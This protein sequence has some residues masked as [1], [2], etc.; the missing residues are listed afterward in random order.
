MQ[1]DKTCSLGA[2][3]R[4]NAR[5]GR[6]RFKRSPRP[7]GACH[8]SKAG[9]LSGVL[10]AG[11]GS[12][13][14]PSPRAP[15]LSLSVDSHPDCLVKGCD[16]CEPFS[17]TQ[18]RTCSEGYKLQPDRTC[19][20]ARDL[21]PRQEGSAYLAMGA[22]RE[23]VGCVLLHGHKR[24]RDPRVCRLCVPAG[25]RLTGCLAPP[26]SLHTACAVQ[27]CDECAT[28]TATKC[29]TCKSGYTR[30]KN[31]KCSSECALTPARPPA[32]RDRII[33]SRNCQRVASIA[34]RR[35]VAP[36]RAAR[37]AD[38]L[39]TAPGRRALTGARQIAPA[40][41]TCPRLLRT[42][43]WPPRLQRRVH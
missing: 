9:E 16:K 36:A 2:C 27:F 43:P 10:F 25:L 17:A 32:R 37:A 6:Q 26:S 29:A 34:T 38:S 18:C 12:A 4:R 28:G 21:P 40:R 42:H 20:C 22:G 3:E 1:A 30:T 8:A 23:V 13:D 24:G 35:R 33:C 15:T 31:D 5:V 41:A 39:P 11:R 7:R 19:F 14:Y